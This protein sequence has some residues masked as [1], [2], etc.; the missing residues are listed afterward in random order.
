[1][2][3]PVEGKVGVPLWTPTPRELD[4]L[5]LLISGCFA[6]PLPGF[7]APTDDSAPI[8]LQV[9]G[10]VADMV[11]AVGQVDLV[12]PEGAPLAR[13]TVTGTWPTD[14]PD[15]LGL[16]GPV[17]RLAHPE[18]G[19]F[20]RLH[21][22]PATLHETV[23]A[24]TL[25][26]VPVHRVL[27]GRDIDEIARAAKD[28]DRIAVLLAC[29]GDGMPQDIS[30]PA[31]VR[32]TLA[33]AP[34][35]GADTAVCAVAAADHGW[36]AAPGVRSPNDW[37]LDSI[38]A[39]YATAAYRVERQP[40]GALPDAVAAIATR[41]RPPRDRQGVVIFFTG[42]SGSGKSTLARALVDHVLEQGDR[43]ITSLDG[44]VVRHHLSKGLGF[45]RADRE[46]NILRIGF[47]AAEIARH[48]GVAICS[49][50]APFESTRSEVRRMVERAGGGFV[51][52]HV[53]TPLE[54]CERRDRKGLY[55]KARAGEIPDFT[56]ISSPY[57]EPVDAIKIDTT[58]RDI[59]DCL[60]ELLD[61][62][63]TEGWLHP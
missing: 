17:E 40:T 24:D 6:P 35:I 12:D 34:L 3:T 2:S 54:E 30:G 44:D 43:T 48:G 63:T 10:T 33:A 39:A 45:S 57:E 8:T 32:A 7:V 61:V 53:S 1:M 50:I 22:P 4:D 9:S 31:L 11:I 13:M 20:R 55:A 59:A 51:L 46:T 47:V 37:L 52:V 38:A 23:P 56:G 62:V 29:V 5:D 18:F 19:P 28:Q 36:D 15:G 26:A 14:E 60:A 16:V 42:L 41:D 49:P 25:L 58:N 27:S 21:V